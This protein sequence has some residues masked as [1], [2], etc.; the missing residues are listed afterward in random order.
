MKTAIIWDL[1][2]TLIDSYDVIT[3]S[4]ALTLR[5][6]HITMS[7]EEI[8]QHCIRFS[9]K[10]LF[11]QV[12][13]QYGVAPEQLKLRYGQISGSKYRQIRRMEQGREILEALCSRGIDNYVFTHRG[14]T[15]I[16]VLDHLGLTDFF[17]EIL[18]SQSGFA[19]KPNP[20]AISYLMRKYD[21]DPS[22]TWY[23]GD[24]TIDMQCAQNAGIKGILYLPPNSLD[25]SG[26]AE[27]CI[28]RNLMEIINVVKNSRR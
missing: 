24:R 6:W 11:Q 4:I 16:P 5:E 1:D 3:D 13:Q 27:S 22:N 14:K 28:V 18:T 15:T 8:R 19:R 12:G 17:Q 2:G 20:E 7:L 23:V 9:T 10:S 21:L 26:G 25:V